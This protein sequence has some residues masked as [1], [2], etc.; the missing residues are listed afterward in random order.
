M[1][2]SESTHVPSDWERFRVVIPTVNWGTESFIESPFRTAP[3]VTH[4][5]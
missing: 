3:A 2:R 1:H 5:P 4:P